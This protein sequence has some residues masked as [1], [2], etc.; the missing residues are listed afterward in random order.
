MYYFGN[1]SDISDLGEDI[2]YLFINNF[3]MENNSLS[4]SLSV[5]LLLPF[6]PKIIL[7]KDHLKFNFSYEMGDKNYI[8]KQECNI[9]ACVCSYMKKSEK[10][11]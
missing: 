2:I 7:R 9:C 8:Q 5:S 6:I 1:V 4:L 10:I 11:K 3:S